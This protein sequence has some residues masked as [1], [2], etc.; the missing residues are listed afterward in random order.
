MRRIFLS[1]LVLSIF[2]FDA[3]ADNGD[4]RFYLAMKYFADKDYDRCV[5]SLKSFISRFPEN[6]NIAE[7]R[8]YIAKSL[9]AQG[10]IKRA[11]TVLED[12][13]KRE[14]SYVTAEALYLLADI[15]FAAHDYD[16]AIFNV[17]R[18]QSAYP[19]T[20]FLWNSVLIKSKAMAA[21]GKKEE[22][23]AYFIDIVENC[24]DSDVRQEG[25]LALFDI[26]YQNKDHASLAHLVKKYRDI[27]PDGK[28]L[29][30]A[31]FYGGQASLLQGDADAAADFFNKTISASADAVILD[32]AAKALFDIYISRSDLD[33]IAEVLA[34]INDKSL[35]AELEGIYLIKSGDH[36]G[37]LSAFLFLEKNLL[38]PERLRN[39][40]LN[41]AEALYQLGRLND[42]MAVYFQIVYGQGADVDRDIIRKACYGIGWCFYK[43][44]DI[45][46]SLKWFERSLNGI[47]DSLSYSASLQ[48]AQIY[49]R[50]GD[51]ARANDIY[52]RFVSQDK[53]KDRRDHLLSQYCGLLLEAKEVD[54]A[55]DIFFLLNK[56]FPASDLLPEIRGAM[57]AA[58]FDRALEC[59]ENKDM[60]GAIKYYE[61]AMAAGL[62]DARLRFELGG[63]FEAVGQF[64]NAAVHYRD[65]IY[66]KG[67]NPYRL[68]AYFRLAQC[69]EAVRDSA[70][71]ATVYREIA[72]LN[73][74]ESSVAKEK[75]N[76]LKL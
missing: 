23:H 47:D 57:A 31:Y 28:F 2:R 37:A 58:C 19:D 50:T 18:L 25:F 48:M 33:K 32:M 75:L 36:N 44:N 68:K 51:I 29:A 52:S 56:E 43:N 66:K 3:L 24:P 49:H 13:I 65:M 53:Y 11:I 69:Y 55:L 30:Y 5:G 74:P 35:K 70:K 20:V 7:A 8:L 54:K 26:Y 63:S 14:S 76:D 45:K 12:L 16:N 67:D 41:K 72:A 22:A 73:I 59:K 27:Y 46:S 64:E 38:D 4:G 61:R 9:Y 17:S 71:A 15:Y 21:S 1:L 40:Y 34:R 39:A 42:A 10:D 6:K 60:R 62:D